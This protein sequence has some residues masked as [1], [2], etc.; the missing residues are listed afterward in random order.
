[1]NFFRLGKKEFSLE[2]LLEFNDLLVSVVKGQAPM[3]QTLRI[4]SEGAS[5]KLSRVLSKLI[6]SLHRGNSLAAS[7]DEQPGVFHR[8]YRETVRAGEQGGFLDAVLESFSSY[9]WQLL[10]LRRRLGQAMLYPILVVIVAYFL[11]IFIGGRTTYTFLNFYTE[12]QREVPW[13]LEILNSFFVV[14]T[15]WMWVVPILFGVGWI[16]WMRSNDSRM[17]SLSG[18]ARLM[19][20]VPG[21]SHI[22]RLH[23]LAN[24]TEL[25]STMMEQQVPFA[26][27]FQIS[28]RASG[29]ALLI[30]SSEASNATIDNKANL[31]PFLEWLM[32]LG[33]GDSKVGRPMHYAAQMYRRRADTATEWL[34]I[35]APFLFLVFIGGGAT[36][37]YV[38]T[39]FYPFTQ[40]L[41]D[42]G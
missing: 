17:L 30:Q 35:L 19:R 25:M 2:E 14:H 31:P 16:S 23:R 21:V 28:A 5:G 36:L 24:F 15:A 22:L 10:D 29:D 40:L 6:D 18:G 34:K 27:A 12:D 39:I 13:S 38:L 42:I 20:L 32:K 11:L 3:E 33:I 26:Q 8:L 4:T 37:F 41:R 7:L 1:M 9:L